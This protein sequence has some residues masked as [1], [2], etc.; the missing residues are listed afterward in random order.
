LFPKSATT[1]TTKKQQLSVTRI[2]ERTSRVSPLCN[3]KKNRVRKAVRETWE[4]RD[5]VVTKGSPS[6]ACHSVIE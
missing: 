6:L 3:N 1:T 2:K 5:N 4:K